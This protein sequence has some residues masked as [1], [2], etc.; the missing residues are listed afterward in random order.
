[1]GSRAPAPSWHGFSRG[2]WLSAQSGIFRTSPSFR[3]T[4]PA[5]GASQSCHPGCQFFEEPPTVPSGGWVLGRVSNHPYSCRLLITKPPIGIDSSSSYHQESIHYRPTSEAGASQ[6][7][8]TAGAVLNIEAS[9]KTHIM[10]LHEKDLSLFPGGYICRT[11][12][13]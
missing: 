5:L 3:T 13:M 12:H 2:W 7:R 8:S 11:D 1:M 9:S 6:S 4:S 10:S